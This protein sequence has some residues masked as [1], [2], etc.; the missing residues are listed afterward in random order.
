MSVIS[1]FLLQDI[2]RHDP[3]LFEVRDEF[4]RTLL[5]GFRAYSSANFAKKSPPAALPLG[6]SGPRAGGLRRATRLASP[7]A[8]PAT[9]AG[10]PMN[11]LIYT[12]IGEVTAAPQVQA[13]VGQACAVASAHQGQRQQ[14]PAPVVVQ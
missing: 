10:R 3:R 11:A 7:V 9:D 13:H 6:P 12:G 8:V 5:L 14:E 2:P 4:K 1:S